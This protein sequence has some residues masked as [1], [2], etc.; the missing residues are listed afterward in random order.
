MHAVHVTQEKPEQKIIQ[1]SGLEFQQVWHLQKNN[2]FGELIGQRKAGVGFQGCDKLCKAKSKGGNGWSKVCLL[3]PN[4]PAI[5][6]LMRL[7]L[8]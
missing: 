5:P 8:H 2:K 6:G 4:Q 1:N 7:C 3:I